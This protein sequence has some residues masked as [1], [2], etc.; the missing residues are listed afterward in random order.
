MLGFYSRIEVQPSVRSTCLGLSGSTALRACAIASCGIAH[1][2]SSFVLATSAR[3]DREPSPQ[4]TEGVFDVQ[5]RV[6]RASMFAR[7]RAT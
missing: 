1:S 3:L 2:F 5:I 7:M 4:V 6:V